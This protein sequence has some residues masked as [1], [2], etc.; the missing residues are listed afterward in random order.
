VDP[1]RPVEFRH[2]GE[3]RLEARIVERQAVHVRVD[4]DPQRSQLIHCPIDL[5]ERRVHVVQRHSCDE[6]DEVLPTGAHQLRHLV[7]RQTGELGRLGRL[8]QRLDRRR[9]ETDDLRVVVE[10]LDYAQPLV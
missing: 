7:V 9:C 10:G 3:H 5:G 6:A 2:V 4:L 8:A 1:D